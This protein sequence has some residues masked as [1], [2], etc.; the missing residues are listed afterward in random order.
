M[1]SLVIPMTILLLIASVNHIQGLSNTQGLYWGYEEGVRYN[2]TK[3]FFKEYNGSI[4]THSESLYGI[5]PGHQELLPFISENDS[6]PQASFTL[7]FL[8]GTFAMDKAIAVPIGNWSIYT[9]ILER[10]TEEENI[11]LIVIDT[12]DSWGYNA[13]TI[14]HRDFTFIVVSVFSKQDGVI[15]ENSYTDMVTDV[16]I[17]RVT[18]LR[19]PTD[20]LIVSLAITASTTI[21]VLFVIIILTKKRSQ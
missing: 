21:I 13:T 19:N 15:V 10:W 6:I 4:T 11:S 18:L 20:P 12:E 2:F 7:N 8:N 9:R 3:D 5:A 17:S 14:S 1:K 16:F